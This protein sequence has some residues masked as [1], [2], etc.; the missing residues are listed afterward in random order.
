M[1][2]GQAIG[3]IMHKLTRVIYGMLKSKKSFDPEVDKKNRNKTVEQQKTGQSEQVKRQIE[4]E[5]EQIKNAPCSNRAFKKK[6]AELLPQ[7]S[8][9][10]ANT[11]S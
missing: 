11:R 8:I 5:I 7:T 9:E 1:K 3:V 10:E 4:Q 2:D 6:K